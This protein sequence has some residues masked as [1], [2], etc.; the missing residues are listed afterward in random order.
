MVELGSCHTAAEDVDFFMEHG[1]LVVKQA[2]SREQAT[3]FT[4]DMWTRLG[5]DPH[6]QSTWPV[7]RDR[8]HMP[9]HKQEPVATFA[10]R[11]SPPCKLRLC[12]GL[13]FLSLFLV[14]SPL[15]EIAR[16]LFLFHSTPRLC[17]SAPAAAPCV[18]LCCA[19]GPRLPS[20]NFLISLY[21][22]PPFILRPRPSRRSSHDRKLMGHVASRRL[23]IQSLPQTLRLRLR[24][25][26][27]GHNIK[28][29]P[30]PNVC[31]GM[32]D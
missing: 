10:P 25:C 21:L 8:I 27:R 17:T 18:L 16:S 13:R 29:V 24:L 2:F 22:F 15:P 30:P 9:Y 19:L 3:E 28:N 14:R 6:D 1:Y 32:T 12:S 20:A 23:A 7:D 11:V 31:D 5:L 4:K 26:I